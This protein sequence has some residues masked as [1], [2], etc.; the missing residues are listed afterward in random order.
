MDSPLSGLAAVSD[1]QEEQY[2]LRAVVVVKHI[3]LHGS[4]RRLA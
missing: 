2:S 1:A 4:R 3:I